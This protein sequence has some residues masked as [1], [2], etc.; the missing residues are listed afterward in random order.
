MKRPLLRRLRILAS[1]ATAAVLSSCGLFSA[2]EVPTTA[3][4]QMTSFYDFETRTLA[5]E[6]APLAQYRGNVA[7]VVNVASKCGLT[8]QYEGLQKLHSELQPRGFVVLAFPSNDFGGQEPG[9]AEEIATFCSTSYGVTF[10]MFTKLQTKTGE[11]Q[12]PL[13]A[14]LGAATG[15]LPGWN[16]GKYLIGK[17]GRVIAFFDSRTGPNDPELRKA[18]DTALA[19]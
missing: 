12:S 14:H 2:R 17:D 5:G 3:E 13:Y 16:F 6:P 18:I 7:L 11:G 1:A 9:S 8:P 19:S 15:S 4:A 10:P